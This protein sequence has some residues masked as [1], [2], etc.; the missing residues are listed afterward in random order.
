MLDS[1]PSAPTFNQPQDL[2]SSTPSLK[3]LPFN[4]LYTSLYHLGSSLLQQPSNWSPEIHPS[5]TW[6]L[7][8]LILNSDHVTALLTDLH[9]LPNSHRLQPPLL[10]K[11]TGLCATWS[12]LIF[13]AQLSPFLVCNCALAMLSCRISTHISAVFSAGPL[14]PTF[15][16][17]FVRL[18]PMFS[19]QR[20][21]IVPTPTILEWV[22]TCLY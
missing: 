2:A 6:S 8:F 21:I 22:I 16:A 17:H 1:S 7:I 4:S 3:P 14:S 19:Y 5:S 11:N 20:D 15:P 9:W 12:L 10:S 13:Q 18:R